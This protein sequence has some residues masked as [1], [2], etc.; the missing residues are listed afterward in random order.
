MARA[1]QNFLIKASSGLEHYR[2]RI[3]LPQGMRLARRLALG[4][5]CEYRAEGRQRRCLFSANVHNRLIRPAVAT[6]A[7]LAAASPCTE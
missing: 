6:L 7:I 2:G 1:F 5:D 3:R 4:R